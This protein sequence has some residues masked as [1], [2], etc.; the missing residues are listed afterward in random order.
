[1]NYL[2]RGRRVRVASAR[3]VKEEKEGAS[4]NSNDLLS[5]GMIIDQKWTVRC[6]ALA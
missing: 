5:K 4:N 2:T 1:M 6:V 3:D